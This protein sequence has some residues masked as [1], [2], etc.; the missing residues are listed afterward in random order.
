[1][2]QTAKHREIMYHILRDI[3]SW[4]YA[5]N[6]AF[7]S[8][9]L[10]YFIHQLD[11]FSTD[12]D[13]DLVRQVDN[14]TLFLEYI[15]SVLTK[16]GKIKQ[17]TR[18]DYSFVFVMNYGENDMNLKLEINTKI[19]AENQYEIINLYGLEM[20]A[21]DRSTIFANKLV[22]IASSKIIV[23]RDIYDVY[24]FFQNKFPINE[25]VV[26]ERTGKSLREYLQFLL[27]FLDAH[28]NRD[29]LVDGLDELLDTTQKDFA[30]E[31]LASEI[32]GILQ[33]QSTLL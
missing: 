28:M 32:L 25:A 4:E 2:L 8:S 13:I 9:T 26:R 31:K 15:E 23:N 17:K 21:Q 10:C 12:L 19:W 7:T 20:L 14:E 27:E 1:M 22:T 33:L 6:L 18:K 3:F 29:N 5:T 30:R 11:R 16:Y 24:F